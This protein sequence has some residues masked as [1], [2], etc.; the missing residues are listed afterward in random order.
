MGDFTFASVTELVR[1]IATKQVSPVE[2]VRAQELG[3][4]PCKRRRRTAHTLVNARHELRERLAH[5]RAD[6]VEHTVCT[7]LD[8][9]DA[10]FN[11]I[12]H[13]D[14][15]HRGEQGGN[16][17]HDRAALIPTADELVGSYRGCS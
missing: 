9:L 6:G 7:I 16:G 4:D 8:E 1:M 13:V 17:Q 3:V 15:L 10:E 5:V 14:E 12:A 2:V 11:E